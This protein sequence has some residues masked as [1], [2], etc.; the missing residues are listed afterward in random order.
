M[1]TS[2]PIIALS[3][4]ALAACWPSARIGALEGALPHT[5][6]NDGFTPPRTALHAG[7]EGS[8]S[9]GAPISAIEALEYAAAG[10]EPLARWRL[11]KLYATG[12]GVPH[13][14]LKAY[15]YFWQIVTS[16]D[17]DNPDRRERRIVSSAFVAVGLYSLS[18]IENTKIRPDAPRALAMFR[19]AATHF[20]DANAQ[21]NL[22]RMYLDGVG[23]EKDSL[24]AVRWL[25]LAA[26]KGHAQAQARLGQMLF[27]GHE[28]LKPQ[29]ALGLMWLTLA[30]DA[31]AGSKKDQWIADLYDTA[32]AAANDEDRE[33]ALAYV[34]GHQ[35]QRN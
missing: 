31:A 6:E 3:L 8:R 15:D 14:D 4:F 25:S 30:R 1:R 11:A 23:I 16:Y 19:Y 17:E 12:Q 29:R 33:V 20:G 18:G 7:L 5:P 9:G 21:Y 27:A 24:Q 28:S 13:D 32:M 34:E 22:A 26:Q 10:G 2:S 35:K